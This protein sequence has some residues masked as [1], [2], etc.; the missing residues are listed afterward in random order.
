MPEGWGGAP[1]SFPEVG[2]V[3][4]AVEVATSIGDRVWGALGSLT[5]RTDGVAVGGTAITRFV[6]GDL[7]ELTDPVEGQ[8]AA[9]YVIREV[10][11]VSGSTGHPVWQITVGDIAPDIV[12][13]M[14]GVTVIQPL[15]EQIRGAGSGSSGALGPAG[16]PLAAEGHSPDQ[17]ADA[18][19]AQQDQA[20]V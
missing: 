5:W 19:P 8:S 18:R 20:A 14:R 15:Q 1:Y 4:V 16:V 17:R 10:E 6:P 3:A 13:L 2:T 9:R 11:P 12:D 7:I